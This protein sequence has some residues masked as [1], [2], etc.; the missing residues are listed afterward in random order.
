MSK[1]TPLAVTVSSVIAAHP[2]T[3]Y[4]LV[5]D[6]TNMGRLSPET[7]DATWLGGAT[8]AAPGVRFKGSNRIGKVSWSTKPTITAA[9]RGRRF[10]FQV[11]GASGGHWTY[12]FDPVE[13]GT[14]VTES[15]SQRRPSPPLIRFFQKRAGVTDRAASL[16]QGMTTT[17]ERLAELAIGTDADHTSAVS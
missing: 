15:M 5:A 7:T 6:V 11:P 13:G 2:E 3:L 16:H 17:L 14:R 1:Q 8:A 12:T 9:D 10:S 4:D